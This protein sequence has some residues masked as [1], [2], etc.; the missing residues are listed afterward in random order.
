MIKNTLMKNSKFCLCS[1]CILERRKKKQETETNILHAVPDSFK[2][3]IDIL[4]SKFIY[5]AFS[6]SA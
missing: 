2:N 6:F 5:C 4:Y 3:N 1:A